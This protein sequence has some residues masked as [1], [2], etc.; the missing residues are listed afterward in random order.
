MTVLIL[1]EKPSVARD[2]A[3]VLG[4][5]GRE[6]GCLY[7]AHYRI[8]WCFGHLVELAPPEHYH[9]SWGRWQLEELPMIPERFE[10]SPTEAGLEQLERV[11]SWLTD[12]SCGSVIN[13]CDAG[14]EGELIFGYVYEI[15]GSILPVQRLWIASL[16][17]EA[18]R[19]GMADLKPGELFAPL[20]ASARARSEADWLVGLNATRLLTLSARQSQPT[21]RVPVLSVGRV[22]TPTLALVVRRDQAISAFLPRTT[23]V[24]EALFR[25]PE[26]S[27]YEG[28]MHQG[29]PLAL[30]EYER[31]E[32]AREV[33][34]RLSPERQG[35]ILSVESVESLRQAPQFFDLTSLQREANTRLGYS[36]Q[37]TLDLAQS[38][39]EKHK[40]LT[41]PRTDS[42]C[43]TPDLART[44]GERVASLRQDEAL[45]ELAST[46]T[47]DVSGLS[48]RL[49][50][51]E[52]V[53]DHHAV[54]PTSTPAHRAR[55]SAEERAIYELVA[56]RMLAALSPAARIGTSRVVT[57]LGEWDFV[58]RGTQ[59]L[60]AGWMRME[61]PARAL[62][63]EESR[64]ASGLPAELSRGV[65]VESMRVRDEPRTTRAP[66]RLTEASLLRAME[67]VGKSLEQEELQEALREGGLGTPATRAGMIETLIARGY[68]EREGKSL[69]STALGRSLV[70]AFEAFPALISA[71][72][73]GQWEAALEQIA[74]NKVNAQEFMGQVRRLTEGVVAHYQRHPP[75]LELPEP[76]SVGSCPA[77]SRAL[78]LSEK[79]LWCEGRR[80]KSCEFVLWREVAS[81]KLT[82]GQ[83]KELVEKKKTRVLKGFKS[84][85]GHPFE[86]RL[87]LLECEGSWRVQFL[88][89]EEKKSSAPSATTDPRQKRRTR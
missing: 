44:L 35:H 60:E 47:V 52:A 19:E 68:V 33:T 84:K 31:R 72:L 5:T 77:C 88:F 54:L 1:A 61:P 82:D 37:Q 30:C 17:D 23:F 43:I 46:L 51:A 28:V 89:E 32:Q 67:T 12:G 13:A 50:N 11:K 64:D 27:T 8:T 15:S 73:T 42:R 57:R 10:L 53:T 58:S 25:T 29:E 21:S 26:G 66:A 79:N 2:I 38:L 22:Q 7:N 70:G 86:A 3:R 49:V 6:Q 45:S 39:Y 48:R 71:E 56:R 69:R 55:L 75:Q 81:K 87:E 83:M 78:H 40:L 59:V 4:V 16:T 63:G 74:E 9:E 14:R 76:E 65:R 24:V 20:L 80:S 34:E 85:Q 18:I 41:Y 62:Q 36:A